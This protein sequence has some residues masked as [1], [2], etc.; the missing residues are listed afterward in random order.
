MA[1]KELS[2]KDVVTDDTKDALENINHGQEWKTKS[3]KLKKDVTKDTLESI[4]RGQETDSNKAHKETDDKCND[5]IKNKKTKV[6]RY[7][8]RGHCKYKNN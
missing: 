5:K 4:N 6:C 1:I 2:K 8:N 7:F 3:R